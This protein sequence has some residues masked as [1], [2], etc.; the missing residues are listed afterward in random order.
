[1]KSGHILSQLSSY[2]YPRKVIRSLLLSREIHRLRSRITELE[3]QLRNSLCP[4]QNSIQTP[5]LPENLDP[6]REHGG[7]R[8]SWEYMYS[9]TPNSQQAQRY[10]PAS[11]F[12]FV[13][14]MSSYIDNALP[15]A[16][17]KSSLQADDVFT[18]LFSSIESQP[19]T[20]EKRLRRTNSSEQKPLPRRQE[21]YFLDLFWQSY[22][23]VYPILNEPAF[24]AH[25]NSI[26]IM[27]HEPRK[28][29]ALVDI[30]L[31]VTMQYGT[32][33][34]PSDPTNT[35]VSAAEKGKDAA[36]AGRGYYRRCQALLADELE[37]P[38]ITTI[39]CHIFSIIYLSNAGS[40][41]T[42]YSTLA[43][44][45]RAAVILDLHQ[46]PL[47]DINE[48]ERN[49]RRRLWWTLYAL[50]IKSAM[51]L[52]RP[53]AINLSQVTCRL[54]AEAQQMGLISIPG[55]IKSPEINSCFASNLQFLKL[56]L[57]ARAVYVT[58]YNKCTDILGLSQQYSLYEDPQALE[59]CADFL[60]S[61]ME[62]L[63]TWLHDIP[64]AMKLK[65]EDDGEPFSTDGSALD[66]EP[67]VSV[68]QQRQRLFLEL[69]YHTLAM[70]LFRHFINFSQPYPTST[71][72]TEANAISCVNHAMTIT[73][74]IH[75]MLTETDLLSAWPESLQWHSDAFLSLVGY[76]LA[77][78]GGPQT[79]KARRAIRKAISTF[80][81]LSNSF[82][83]AGDS[84]KMAR[85]LVAK[86]D[87]ILDG[88]QTGP[89]LD[90]LPN[91]DDLLLDS[92]ALLIRED[93]DS[94][95]RLTKNIIE[96]EN[97]ELLLPELLQPF[98]LASSMDCSDS[99]NTD[100]WTLGQN[101]A[102]DPSMFWP[103]DHSQ[104]GTSMVD[105]TI[106]RSNP[107]S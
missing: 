104:I 106:R 73:N 15:M 91:T 1:M 71:R 30:V 22:H 40:H 94:L 100:I 56:I 39:Q 99:L 69:H 87:F 68:L 93:A 36:N 8:G 101:F 43:L 29:S 57:A 32:A 7:N 13:K 75:Q 37:S 90:V 9:K 24:R 103:A 12:Y 48:G 63:K 86:V 76:V 52:G 84:A 74:I 31:A 17:S 58:F 77:S 83:L 79:T 98:N 49:F 55:S 41:N 107:T 19:S 4:L 11:S 64:N 47:N 38:S 44:A 46:E 34:L 53:L 5:C 82:A 66:I 80:D 102:T 6:F 81:I 96:L 89:P 65:R 92:E 45:C 72:A 88:C 105:E 21:E 25:H 14:S 97:S 62:Y 18:S 2:P 33:L 10:K 42:A 60:L 20:H 54:P 50:E 16:Y 28:P 3:G 61:K 78:P 70:N 95:E 67:T 27:P 59:A 35:A 85:D 51:E 23:C 26:W